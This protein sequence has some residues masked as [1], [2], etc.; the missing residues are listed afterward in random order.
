MGFEPFT[1]G[2]VK[3]ENN[4]KLGTWKSEYPNID[5]RFGVNSTGMRWNKDQYRNQQLLI[6]W[7]EGNLSLIPGW[8]IASGD[9]F[10]QFI[11]SL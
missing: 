9:T 6:N 8:N 2:R 11:S 7:T 10:E 3:W 5:I 4:F 1:H